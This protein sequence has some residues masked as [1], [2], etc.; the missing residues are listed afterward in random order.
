MPHLII[1]LAS[2]ALLIGILHTI[3]YPIG[4]YGILLLVLANS[5]DI[6]HFLSQ[7]RFDPHRCSIQAHLLHTYVAI[8]AYIGM[9]FIP[10]TFWFGVGAVQ[11]ISLDM[12]D[13]YRMKKVRGQRIDK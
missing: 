13:C 11:H 4:M 7:P 12:L 5:I 3:Q 9:V 6:D 1:H 8:A 2:N 10:A